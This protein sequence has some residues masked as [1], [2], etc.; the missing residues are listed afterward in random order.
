MMTHGSGTELNITPL[1]FQ[2]SY[3]RRA[4][5]GATVQTFL[6]AENL[7]AYRGE[8]SYPA[9]SPASTAFAGT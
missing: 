7:F 2:G 4:E 1:G 9:R 6:S 3:C 5:S 8:V